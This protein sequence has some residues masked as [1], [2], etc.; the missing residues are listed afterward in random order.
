VT[1]NGHSNTDAALA[2]R[3]RADLV[4]GLRKLAQGPS[5]RPGE[6]TS[7]TPRDG[8]SCDLC[9]TALASDHR[10]LLQLEERRI[11]C[12][13]EACWALRSGDVEYRPVGTRTLWLPDFELSEERWA[14]F[15]IPIGLVF[16]MR[17][18]V[19]GV[20]GLYPSPAGATESEL[21]LVS[22]EALVEENPVLNEL[23]SD[24]EGLIVNR[25][26]D[27]RQYVIAPI[28]QCYALV[29]LVKAKWEGISGGTG[30]ERAIAGF[31]DTLHEQAES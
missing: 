29:G 17:S 1:R 16:F 5:E 11:D 13:C 15:S 8:E 2:A 20:V 30:L 18:S 10:H 6:A 31:F 24:A 28:D 23:E 27:P 19:A 26:A 3:R 22:W 12:C 9:G 14:S 21:D 7:E 4:G 25:L